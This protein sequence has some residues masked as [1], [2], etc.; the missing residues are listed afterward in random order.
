MGI[1]GLLHGTLQTL[2][3]D[4]ERQAV[5]PGEI[6]GRTLG[7]RQTL[8]EKEKLS[9]VQRIIS[10]A[11]CVGHTVGVV[12]MIGGYLAGCAHRQYDIGRD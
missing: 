1:D 4:T 2:Y 5:E 7:R 3:I 12:G 10:H 8:F 9:A 6:A 11:L